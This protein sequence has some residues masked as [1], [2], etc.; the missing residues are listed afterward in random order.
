M[1]HIGAGDAAQPVRPVST[2]F[3]TLGMA[4]AHFIAGRYDG[5]QWT[6]ARRACDEPEP[7]CRL[8]ASLAALRKRMLGKLRRHRTLWQRDCALQP[9]YSI[10]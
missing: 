9:D 4:V 5:R 10:T 2:S 3:L 1:E 8:G 6:G 7:Q